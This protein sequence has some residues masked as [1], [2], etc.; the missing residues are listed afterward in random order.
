M[1]HKTK[2]FNLKFILTLCILFIGTEFYGQFGNRG[3]TRGAFNRQ[4]AI[5]RTQEAPEKEDPKTA[6][7]MVDEQMPSIT[8]ALDL[9]DF[10]VAVM[11]S[12]L[13]KYVQERIEMQILKLPPEKMREGF[14]KINERQTEELQA[15]LPPE[16]YSAFVDLQSNGVAKT[17]KK[18]K[19][20]KK[21][22]KKEKEK[23]NQ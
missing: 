9:N 21:K 19:K 3:N 7:Q 2:Y 22:K 23:E 1:K 16:K 18:K 20:A 5:P 6:A 12:I 14:Q 8:E 4:S 15:S 10:E 17:I 13:K 11:A